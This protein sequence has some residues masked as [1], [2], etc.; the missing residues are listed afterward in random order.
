MHSKRGAA[1]LGVS[2]AAGLA[3]TGCA[4]TKGLYG[5]EQF[6]RINDTHGLPTY[7]ASGADSDVDYFE[8]GK[9]AQ[10]VMRAA[11]PDGNPTLLDGQG[12]DQFIGEDTRRWWWATFTCEHVIPLNGGVQ[13]Q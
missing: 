11:C 12:V 9:K 5:A 13:T 8:A 6:V 10:E 4:G 3:I 2:L 7:K 1:L